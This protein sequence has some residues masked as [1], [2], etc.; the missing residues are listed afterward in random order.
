MEVERSH[1]TDQQEFY[2]L[3]ESVDD[4]GKKLE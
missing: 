2:Q 4:T 3:L 1:L